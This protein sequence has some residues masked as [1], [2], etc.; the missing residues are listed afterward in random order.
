MALAVTEGVLAGAGSD[1]HVTARDHD[2]E[3]R[4]CAAVLA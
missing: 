1:L 3:R 2:P 4:H